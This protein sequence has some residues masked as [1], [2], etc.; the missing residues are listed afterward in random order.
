M[1]T[2]RPKQYPGDECA[3]LHPTIGYCIRSINGNVY[4]YAQRLRLCLNTQKNLYVN[5]RFMLMH[6]SYAYKQCLGDYIIFTF[7]CKAGLYIK[8]LGVHE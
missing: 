7:I 6:K 4:A 2:T 1:L 3:G 8:G 5:I